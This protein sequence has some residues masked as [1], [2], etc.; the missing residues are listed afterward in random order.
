[1]ANESANPSASGGSSKSPAAQGASQ[2]ETQQAAG[3]GSTQREARPSSGRLA[4]REPSGSFGLWGT[5]PFTLMRRMLEDM[6]RLFEG[7]GP[8][9][10]ASTNERELERQI[11]GAAAW[12]PRVEVS[13]R[14]GRMVV[15]ADL[16][17]LRKEDVR[18][19]VTD[20]AI[21]IEGERRQER[22]VE[23]SGVYRSEVT[24]GSFYRAIPLPEGANAD[25]AEAR[26]AN[27]VLEITIPLQ[28]QLSLIHI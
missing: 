2:R 11:Q 18:V 4:R 3:Q 10:F 27:G 26:F 22:E 16:P 28:Q 12:A 24:Y 23:G 19:E 6:D 1:M 21:T 15:R 8:A 17:G 25:A 5:S 7:S 20:D 14:D 9:R 13:E